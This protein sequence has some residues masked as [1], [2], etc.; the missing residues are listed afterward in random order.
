MSICQVGSRIHSTSLPHI[1]Q[2]IAVSM[3]ADPLQ[4]VPMLGLMQDSH[5]I[6][7]Q[8]RLITNLKGVCSC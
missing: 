6:C 8:H 5:E 1:A 7:E 4:F 3:Q 2:G